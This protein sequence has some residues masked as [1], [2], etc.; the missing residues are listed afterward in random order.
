[1]FPKSRTKHYTIQTHIFSGPQS[2][3]LHSW[4]QVCFSCQNFRDCI[5][6]MQHT[7]YIPV[8]VNYAPSQPG[9]RQHPRIEQTNTSCVNYMN[10]YFERKPT[11][12]HICSGP[13]LPLNGFWH[14]TYYTFHFQSFVDFRFAGK[15]LCDCAAKAHSEDSEVLEKRSDVLLSQSS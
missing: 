7:Y 2:L 3:I 10:I 9:L 6:V 11:S 13:V 8:Y 15:R 5:K 14:R 4:G 1:M 12:S